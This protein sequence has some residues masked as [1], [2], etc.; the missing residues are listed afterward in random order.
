MSISCTVGSIFDVGVW[1]SN[2][3]SN[4]Y[5][6]SS[7]ARMLGDSSD[8]S[9]AAAEALD[10]TLLLLR[11]LSVTGPTITGASGGAARSR[12][13]VGFVLFYESAENATY[14]RQNELAPLVSASASAGA[15]DA[16]R[17]TLISAHG[18]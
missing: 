9:D 12:V 14:A 13:S 1:I 11:A 17:L 18:A 8:P 16:F 10:N 2:S 7:S 4:S 6:N 3:N 15:L 5:G